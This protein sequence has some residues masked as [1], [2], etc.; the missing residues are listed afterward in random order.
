MFG[1]VRVWGV[2]FAMLALGGT[3]SAADANKQILERAEHHKADALKFWEKL[4]NID[5]GTGDTDGLKEV[6]AIVMEQLVKSAPRLRFLRRS[7]PSATTSSR[8]S[9]APAKARCF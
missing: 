3:A 2:A 9:P 6:S 8:A 1:K 7:P 5:S 4:V